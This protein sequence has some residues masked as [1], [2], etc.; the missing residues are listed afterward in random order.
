LAVLCMSS[1]VIQFV[2]T[3]DLPRALT[4]LSVFTKSAIA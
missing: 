4:Y 3:V 1:F 2:E